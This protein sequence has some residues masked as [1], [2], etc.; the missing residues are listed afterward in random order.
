MQRL[1]DPTS[2]PTQLGRTGASCRIRVGLWDKRQHRR[3][4]C[5]HRQCD[6]RDGRQRTSSADAVRKVDSDL[7][8]LRMNSLARTCK[9]CRKRRPR[10]PCPLNRST[11]T[12]IP[13]T[14]TIARHG[15]LTDMTVTMTMPQQLLKILMVAATLKY[16][17]SLAAQIPDDVRAR[18]HQQLVAQTDQQ[19]HHHPNAT[20]RRAAP[21]DW[22][23][24]AGYN[25][26]VGDRS[27]YG[28]E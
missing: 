12:P 4:A 22:Q 15:N 27:R 3:C 2:S 18:W 16:S 8:E 9:R 14:T 26:M 13:P 1:A 28:S 24:I 25:A 20:C 10:A 19:A 7:H 11:G 6:R 21:D 17:S 5:H 23:G